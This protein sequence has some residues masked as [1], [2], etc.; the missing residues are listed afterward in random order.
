MFSYLTEERKILT[1]V[2]NEMLRQVILVWKTYSKKLF[3]H[4]FG[5]NF[6]CRYMKAKWLYI[7]W[8]SHCDTNG[9]NE[10]HITDERVE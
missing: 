6:M 4:I 9:D 8:L 5:I 10:M 3:K 1:Q 7:V 2:L